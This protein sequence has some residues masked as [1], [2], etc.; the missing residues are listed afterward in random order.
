LQVGKKLKELD[1]IICL[2]NKPKGLGENCKVTNDNE[3]VLVRRG[4]KKYSMKN[5]GSMQKD[6]SS[7][8]F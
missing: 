6:Y 8:F 2:A 5:E 1:R 7:H 4:S 3:F